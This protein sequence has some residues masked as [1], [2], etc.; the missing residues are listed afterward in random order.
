MAPHE[1]ECA[2]VVVPCAAIDPTL[3]FVTE[4]LGFVVQSVVAADDPQR[5]VVAA[6]GIRLSL[7]RSDAVASIVVRLRCSEAVRDRL[8]PGPLVA[9]NG[10]R[11][12]LELSLP[13]V[14]VPPATAGTTVARADGT[15]T[16]GRAGMLYRDLLA[17]RLG[18]HAI[19]SHIRITDAGPVP[20]YVHFHRVRFQMIFCAHGWVRVVYED[21][22]EPFV[23]VAGDCVLQPPQI[24]HRVLESSAGLEVV[25][26]GIPA[27]HET[28]A[29]PSMDLPTAHRRREREFAGQR[30]VRHEAAGATWRPAAGPGFEICDTGIAHATHGLADVQVVRAVSD[31]ADSD[32]GRWVAQE[33]TLH[34]AFVLRGR[35][36]A[37]LARGGAHVLNRSDAVRIGAGE[38]YAWRGATDDL[39]LLVVTA[40]A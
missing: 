40:N 12:E 28:H 24:R 22:G 38:R 13:P 26:V 27:A 39:Q 31:L 5:V 36:T 11:F 29:D 21:Q 16:A 7:E 20:D 30:F 15:W 33:A 32:D 14:Q 18:G 34:L 3:A 17:D 25:E 23:M 6:H 4:R 9:P 19:A 35:V 2:E 1:I 37:R 8:G 10:T